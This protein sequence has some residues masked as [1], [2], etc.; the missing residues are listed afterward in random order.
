VVAKPAQGS[1]GI[2]VLTDIKTVDDLKKAL[3]ICFTISPEV[4]VEEQI[5]GENYRLLIITG[6]LMSVI[7]RTPAAVQGDGKS[8]IAELIK[9][10]NRAR[11]DGYTGVLTKIKINA[12][13]K[14]FLQKKN[15]NLKTIPGSGET[16]FL[17]SRANTGLGGNSEMIE[18]K[19]VHPTIL[20]AIKKIVT[21][22]NAKGII[23]VDL[24][25][26]DLGA[27]LKKTKGAILELETAPSLRSHPETVIDALLKKLC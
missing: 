5:S 14:N 18:K 26:S 25:T 20:Q 15:Q 3:H 27:S 7:K 24:I 17:D 23:A 9:K 4:I 19:I 16:V 8:T 1:H 13:L 11:A 6:K 2:G 22:T 21:A 12:D 10:T